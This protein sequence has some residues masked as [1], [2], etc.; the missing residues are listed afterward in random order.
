MT[1]GRPQQF[2]TDIA[3]EA[4]MDLFW[5]KGYEACS[6]QD[7]L[8]ATRL[9]KSS[10]YKTFFSKE[11]L[12]EQCLIR[13]QTQLAKN[14]RMALNESQSGIGFIETIL[15]ENAEEARGKSKK[16]GCFLLNTA[17]EFAQEKPA[18]ATIVSKGISRIEA[19]FE[20]AVVL[21]QKNREIS[22]DADA[23]ELAQF[24]FNSFTGL[25]TRVKAGASQ[26]E[27]KSIIKMTIKAL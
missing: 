12:F 7:L 19:I 5:L 26:K 13:Y 4:A 2:D 1:L 6:L 10:L 17:I 14:M 23:K 16:I 22:E 25:K 21:A 18:L 3:L 20:D 9:S 8:K 24:I 15:L 11:K 27:V